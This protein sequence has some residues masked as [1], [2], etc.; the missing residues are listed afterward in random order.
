[1][2]LIV[3]TTA[4]PISA[5]LDG[6]LFNFTPAMLVNIDDKTFDSLKKIKLIS[7]SLDSGALT[8]GKKAEKV[9]TDAKKEMADDNKANKKK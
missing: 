3:N 2:P 8:V 5:Y 9:G 1:M 4:A 7:R 6:G